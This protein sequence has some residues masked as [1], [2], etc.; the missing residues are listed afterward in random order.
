MA[1]IHEKLY[2]KSR[3]SNERNGEKDSGAILLRL[4]KLLPNSPSYSAHVKSRNSGMVSPGDLTRMAT[5]LHCMIPHYRT[6]RWEPGTS[7]RNCS[8]VVGN[9]WKDV[10]VSNLGQSWSR[11]EGYTLASSQEFKKMCLERVVQGVNELNESPEHP[12]SLPHAVDTITS[13]SGRALPVPNPSMLWTDP[14][15]LGLQDLTANERYQIV[16]RSLGSRGV[17]ASQAIY[18]KVKHDLREDTSWFTGPESFCMA[19][20]V[21]CPGKAQSH[22]FQICQNEDAV[23]SGILSCLCRFKKYCLECLR[24]IPQETQEE[25]C[26]P[27]PTC[28][29][30]VYVVSYSWVMLTPQ[31][32]EHRQNSKISQKAEKRLQNKANKL[33]K[34]LQSRDDAHGSA[35][36]PANSL[37][38]PSSPHSNSYTTTSVRLHISGDRMSQIK[39]NI[40]RLVRESENMTLATYRACFPSSDATDEEILKL[41]SHK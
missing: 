8:W 30:S 10:G 37:N 35:S 18:K 17:D 21:V 40:A 39:R 12:E 29:R 9:F 26:L 13:D 34:R 24:N 7:L 32:E 16:S 5:V 3:L 31:E 15:C 38:L 14:E 23:I 19:R 33:L 36:S 11:E 22:T 27:C 4:V 1:A 28:R 41:M 25:G 20:T 2:G 6:S